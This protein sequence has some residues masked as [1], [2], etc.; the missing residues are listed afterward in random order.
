MNFAKENVREISGYKVDLD[1][2]GVMGHSLGGT[3]ITSY[4]MEDKNVKAILFHSPASLINVKEINVP[5]RWITGDLDRFYTSIMNL[6]NASPSPS[7]LVSLKGTGHGTFVDPG[8]FIGSETFGEPCNN[9]RIKLS[10][11]GSAS[12]DF[13][14]KYVKGIES[15]DE[16][17]FEYDDLID[18]YL[19]R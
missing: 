12:V 5:T 10:A 14:N 16:F 2:L 13:L 17:I 3:S 9:Q 15:G 19:E 1:N 11:I 4:Q 8:C 6:F 7:S 18:E